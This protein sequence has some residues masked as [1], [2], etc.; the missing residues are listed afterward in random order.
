MNLEPVMLLTMLKG[1]DVKSGIKWFVPLYT[2]NVSQQQIMIEQ[3]LSR[4]TTYLADTPR[5]IFTEYLTTLRFRQRKQCI[6][7]NHINDNF[8]RP[9]ASNAQCN[10]RSER[11]PDAGIH[12]D[13]DFHS[14]SQNV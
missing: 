5:S 1:K 7:Q 4:D 2:P 14:N 9:T 8:Y 3:V 11:N 10:I 13:N 6:L 12:C